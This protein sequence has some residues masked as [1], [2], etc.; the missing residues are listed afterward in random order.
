M[1]VSGAVHECEKCTYVANQENIVVFP[2]VAKKV[3]VEPVF[4]N[5][6]TMPGWVGH[7][8]F[9]ALQCVYCRRLSV[10]YPHGYT[11]LGYLFLTCQN[12]GVNLVLDCPEHVEIYKKDAMEPPP[13]ILPIRKQAKF[14][15]RLWERLQKKN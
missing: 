13:S 11:R 5:F 8:A 4:I 14:W 1:R 10:D 9:Y 3:G 15:A 7:A 12:C 6:F 2:D